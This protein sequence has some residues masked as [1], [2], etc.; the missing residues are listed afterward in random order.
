MRIPGNLKLLIVINIG[1][2][3]SLQSCKRDKL[4]IPGSNSNNKGGA[5]SGAIVS[6]YAGSTKGYVDGPV[7]SAKFIIAN[8]LCMGPDG[9]LYVADSN[10]V[11]KIDRKGNVSTLANLSAIP[12]VPAISKIT[13]MTI[14]SSGLIYLALDFRLGSVTPMGDISITNLPG[15]SADIPGPISVGP[16]GAFYVVSS[17]PLQLLI[18][19]F[20]V[21]ENQ[22][23]EHIQWYFRQSV[24]ALIVDCHN[25]VYL[26]SHSDTGSKVYKMANNIIY[27]P[28]TTATTVM[29]EQMA[30]DTIAVPDR[31]QAASFTIT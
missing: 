30:Q 31:A 24:I 16:D 11:R 26:I 21:P 6:T 13:S 25:N 19:K 4:I 27:N 14:A 15:F 5:N 20:K 8:Y 28:G 29:T 17:K 3:I 12:A 10:R 9:N 22:K 23:L 7:S 18:D 2:V 1:L